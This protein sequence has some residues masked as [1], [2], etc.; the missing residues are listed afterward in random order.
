MRVTWLVIL[1]L[2]SACKHPLEIA[3]EG[4]IVERNE[5]LRGCSAEEYAA[6][7]GNCTDNNVSEDESVLYQALPRSGWRFSHWEGGCADTA[8]EDVCGFEYLAA[9]AEVWDEHFPDLPGPALKAVFEE[10]RDATQGTSYIA[11]NFGIANNAFSAALDALF[12][13][14]SSY[15]YTTQRAGTRSYF[16]RQP[17]LFERLNSGILLTS[18]EG[19]ERIGGAALPDMSFITLVDTDNS[20][21][22]SSVS[23]LTPTLN[24]ASNALLSGA[25]YCGSIGTEGA[26]RFARIVVDGNGGG[27]FQ[28]IEDRL[29]ASGQAPLSYSVSEDGTTILNYSNVQLVGSMSADGQVFVSSQLQSNARGASI[30]IKVSA[31]HTLGTLAGSYIGA[32]SSTQPGMGVTEILFNEAGFSAES[33]HIDSYGLRNYSLGRDFILVNYDGRLE[34]EFTDG[35]VSYNGQLAFMVNTDPGKFPTLVVYIRKS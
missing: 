8:Q 15:R 11:S 33:V 13:E 28:L 7:F 6:E 21:G 2:L 32:L 31:N 9:W 3:G 18:H 29:G 25:Y 24:D 30:C 34:A 10:D 19:E 35:A 26:A 5:G 16:Y 20:D 14:D 22:D 1:L 4:D 27:L 12:M 23:L 17:G